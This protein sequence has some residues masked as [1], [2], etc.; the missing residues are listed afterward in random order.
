MEASDRHWKKIREQLSNPFLPL[1]LL[2]PI[3]HHSITRGMMTSMSSSHHSGLGKSEGTIKKYRKQ[4]IPIPSLFPPKLFPLFQ[5]QSKKERKKKVSVGKASTASRAFE[6]EK[7]ENGRSKKHS[8]QTPTAPASPSRRRQRRQRHEASSPEPRRG[9]RC[10]RRRTRVRRR[11]NSFFLFVERE[12]IKA[13]DDRM[14]SFS[15]GG[16]KRHFS[17]TDWFPSA[18]LG[19]RR[20]K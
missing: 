10:R 4:S 8:P 15:C 19:T 1:P 6:R 14:P 9:R 7:K 5:R 13:G 2:L 11:E 3:V 16:K 18:L 12:A 17:T 20:D